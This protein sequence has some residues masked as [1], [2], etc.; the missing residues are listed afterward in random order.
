MRQGDF[1]VLRG[2]LAAGER[3]VVGDLDWAVE[4]MLLAPV[5][6]AALLARLVAEATGADAVP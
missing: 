5:E 1:V 2:G 6:D 4:G 3:I